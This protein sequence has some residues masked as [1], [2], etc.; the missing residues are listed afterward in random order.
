VK[1]PATMKTLAA[2]P[3]STEGH[4][5]RELILSMLQTAP[6]PLRIQTM[7]DQLDVH[8][9]TVRFHLD[10]LIDAGRVE[11]LA[12]EVTGPGRPPARY[13]ARQGMDRAGPSNYQLLA[14]MLTSHLKATSHDPAKAAVGVGRAW[15]P[16]LLEA[17]VGRARRSKT[18][19]LS[20]LEEKL[21]EVGF[22]PEPHE[23]RR[24]TH[25]R[26]RHCPFLGLA[27]DDPETICAIHL[28]LMQG[29]VGALNGPVTIDRLDPFVEPDLCVAYLGRRATA[30]A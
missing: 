8:P 27:A 7:A 9:N 5:R 28:G 30:G 16:S 13:R 3:S 23:G 26:L 25:I 4:G 12:G 19:V 17:P 18:E 15:G 22:A 11:R 20:R 1:P 6:A 29:V 2:S 21:A 24:T 10:A 14:A